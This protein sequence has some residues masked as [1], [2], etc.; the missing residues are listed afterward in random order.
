MSVSV[1]QRLG[2]SSILSEK[3]LAIGGLKRKVS[4]MICRTTADGSKG[5][6]RLGGFLVPSTSIK[7]ALMLTA[8]RCL[9]YR[10][11]GVVTDKL[12]HMRSTVFG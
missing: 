5:K 11:L 2:D 8:V 6:V 4:E 9:Q 3:V 10:R 12:V 7:A 1:N